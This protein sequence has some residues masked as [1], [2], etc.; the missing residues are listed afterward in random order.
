M[1]ERLDTLRRPWTELPQ[2]TKDAILARI[3]E[4]RYGPTI[5]KGQHRDLEEKEDESQMD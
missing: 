2:P 4:N 3:R 5:Y 1:L